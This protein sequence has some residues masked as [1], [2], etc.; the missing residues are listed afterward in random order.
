MYGTHR[1]CM[2]RDSKILS[3]IQRFWSGLI[4]FGFIAQGN[5]VG[6]VWFSITSKLK[7]IKSMFNFSN[8]VH[9]LFFSTFVS[10]V[11][12]SLQRRQ[13]KRYWTFGVLR[14]SSISGPICFNMFQYI[15]ICFNVFFAFVFRMG[16]LPGQNKTHIWV[17]KMTMGVWILEMPSTMIEVETKARQS[18]DVCTL[19][20]LWQPPE[21]RKA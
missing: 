19:A 10:Q 18:L 8:F 2:Q 17:D 3:L 11:L 20:Q 21:I 16:T 5:L 15:S 13:C 6:T 12:R 14:S 7:S 1:G 4:H 9:H